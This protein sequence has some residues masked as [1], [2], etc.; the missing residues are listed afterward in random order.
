MD[1][2]L[3]VDR[4]P[5]PCL[6][7]HARH[8]HGDRNTYVLDRCRCYPCAAASSAYEHNRHRLGLYGRGT[9]TQL[10]DAEPAREH[11]RALT[12]AGLGWKR[13]A[14]LASV[15][16]STVC[17][18]LY[19]RKRGEHREPP[20]ARMRPGDASKLLAVPMP[21]LD[22]LG[23]AQLVDATGTHRRLQALVALGWSQSKLAR[24]LG[25]LPANFP[26]FM[27]NER[28][29]VRH[30]VA[31]RELYDQ[32]SLTGPTAASG[33]EARGITMALRY[34]AERGWAPPLAWDDESLDDP[35]AKPLRV[36]GTRPTSRDDVDEVAV[37][38]VAAGDRTVRLTVAERR[39]VVLRLVEAGLNDQQIEARTGISDRTCLRIRH[40]EHAPLASGQERAADQA[41]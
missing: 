22:D 33:Y 8:Q 10:V 4:T 3:Y 26:P 41:V 14:D 6:H 27:R 30:A 29:L 31:V 21:G 36:I 12:A 19:G 39:L 35:T 17:R 16:R 18:L 37:D 2:R 11:V 23:G 24:R 13:V 15:H 25:I 40:A 34:A 32:L 9:P 28:V 7:K 20:T 38:R 5:K 1:G